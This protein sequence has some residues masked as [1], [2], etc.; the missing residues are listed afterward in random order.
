MNWREPCYGSRSRASVRS[1]RLW[2][3]WPLLSGKACRDLPFPQNVSSVK[4][5]TASNASGAGAPAHTTL[6]R[7]SLS[8]EEEELLHCQR[9]RCKSTIGR[10]RGK[11][12]SRELRD[13]ERTT[14][15]FL[16][17]PNPECR[18]KWELV[19]A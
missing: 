5:P 10:V 12:I 14:E 6:R 11:R 19:A 8:L 15:D 2:A 16:F 17:C 13:N 3:W 18:A 4:R 7:G 1:L 9:S